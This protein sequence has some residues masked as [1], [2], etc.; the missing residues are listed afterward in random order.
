MGK[1]KCVIAVSVFV[2]FIPAILF[3][4]LFII[5]DLSTVQSNIFLFILINFANLCGLLAWYSLIY[6]TEKWLRSEI[7]S[8]KFIYRG[9]AFAAT[10]LCS[11]I[12][13]TGEIRFIPFILFICTPAILHTLYLSYWH[14]K[15]FN[16]MNQGTS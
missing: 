14:I 1:L 6:L 2:L 16:Q 3:Y 15:H 9:F 13:T 12:F 7:V 8:P 10:G 5:Y 11:I 4:L